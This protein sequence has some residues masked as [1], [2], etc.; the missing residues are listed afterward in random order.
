MV[1]YAREPDNATKSC[2]V[3]WRPKRTQAAHKL[4]TNVLY[5]ALLLSVAKRVA[6][7]TTGDKAADAFIHSRPSADRLA[8]VLQLR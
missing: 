4:A 1:K 6:T 7:A 8:V 2:K 5:H 3:C